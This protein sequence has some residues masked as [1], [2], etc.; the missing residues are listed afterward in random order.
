MATTKST[1]REE[2]FMSRHWRGLVGFE[3]VLICVCDFM[4]LPMLY[5]WVQQYEVQAANDAY[6][7]WSP[8]TVQGGGL[9]HLSHM[10]IMGVSSWGKTQERTADSSKM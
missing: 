4:I 7:Q 10:A 5:F 1:K 3:Y 9:Y 2:T 8:L 6:R